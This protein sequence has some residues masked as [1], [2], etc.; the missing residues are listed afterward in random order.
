M[1]DDS[2]IREVEQELRSDKIKALWTRFGPA[3]IGAVVVLVLATAAWEGWQYYSAQR[4]NAAGDRLLAA[5]EA[6]E[7]GDVD[8]ARAILAELAEDGV[9]RYDVLAQMLDASI[10]AE[11]DPVAAI[12]AFRAVAEDS[13]T[14]PAIADVARVRAAYL[15]VDHGDPGEVAALVVPLVVDGEPLR[16]SAREA[17]G[18]ASWRAGDRDNAAEQFRTILADGNAPPALRAR[19]EEMLALH[20]ALG[21]AVPEPEP[22]VSTDVEPAAVGDGDA[23]EGAVPASP[24]VGLAPATA[25]D[26]TDN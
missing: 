26:V 23:I 24:A 6:G 2:F 7:T 8:E 20:A 17:V 10:V 21:G 1:A 3:I 15:L 9:G 18:L 22:V 13:D 25:G 11:S 19:A 5:I 4:A 14:P 16:H 12:A